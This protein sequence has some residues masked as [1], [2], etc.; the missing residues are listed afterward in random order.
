MMEE[1][2]IAALNTLGISLDPK[3]V[4]GDNGQMSCPDDPDR[5]ERSSVTIE[6]Y[7]ILAEWAVGKNVL[8][9]GTGLGVA[10]VGMFDWASK[11]EYATLGTL[12][13]CEI[14]A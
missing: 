7:R 12:T 2:I 14:P 9:I 8:E 4:I 3:P 1:E 5:A 6:E 10:T 11:K 13:F